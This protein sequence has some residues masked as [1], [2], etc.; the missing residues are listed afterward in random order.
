MGDKAVNPFLLAETFAGKKP[1][2]PKKR[3]E[4]VPKSYPASEKIALQKTTFTDVSFIKALTN[5]KSTREFGNKPVSKK[6]IESI[7]Y[8]SCGINNKNIHGLPK[9]FYPSAGARYPL[10]LYFLSL[11]TA[12]PSGLYHFNV[13][14]NSLE[15]LKPVRKFDFKRYIPQ[16]DLTGVA[17]FLLISA[18]FERTTSKYG[19]RGYRYAFMEAGHLGQNIALL[20]SAL[21]LG[22]CPVGGGFYEN[23][24]NKLI[25]IDGVKESVIYIFA[26]G[27]IRHDK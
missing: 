11:N 19:G 6:Q 1:K 25:G 12:F 8:L 3:S 7:L 21:N 17:C 24:V 22:S 10:E 26:L 23:R 13:I 16:F 14:N 15:K 18:V 5:R 20:A 9:R 2:N 4:T 27:H